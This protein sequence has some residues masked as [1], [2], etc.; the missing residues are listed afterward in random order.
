MSR[1]WCIAPLLLL[2]ALSPVSAQQRS[3][4]EPGARVRL[5]AATA[6]I[7]KHVGTLQA[8]ELDT[9]VVDSLR[10]PIA[11][12]TQL[13]ISRGRRSKAGRGALIGAGGGAVAGGI[14]GYLVGNLCYSNP[15]GSGCRAGV[16][17][18]GAGVGSAVGAGIG[19][20]IGRS[21]TSDRWEVLLLDQLRLSTVPLESRVAVILSA[22]F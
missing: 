8:V 9:L 7:R 11:I 20:L 10:V 21:A 2:T 4:L 13:E 14:V 17:A 5:S 12:I 3:S 1:P 22:H 6:G 18:L 16:T 19:A 15:S